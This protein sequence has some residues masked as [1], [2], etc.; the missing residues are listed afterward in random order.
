[1]GERDLEGIQEMTIFHARATDP[2]TSHQAAASI[3]YFS[4]KPAQRA[5]ITIIKNNPAI[6]DDRIYE[7]YLNQVQFGLMP[8][9]T[10]QAIRTMRVNLWRDGFIQVS[11]LGKNRFGRNIRLWMVTEND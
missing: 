2:N 9:Y 5:I 1:M 8:M 4:L 11:G 10:P 7:L 6:G 3:N